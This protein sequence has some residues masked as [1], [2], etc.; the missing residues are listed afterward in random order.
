MYDTHILLA[1]VLLQFDHCYKCQVCMPVHNLCLQLL[2]SV[3]FEQ[4][5]VRSS[6][7]PLCRHAVVP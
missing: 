2:V 3:Q 6:L 7:F 5:L 4:S 1:I